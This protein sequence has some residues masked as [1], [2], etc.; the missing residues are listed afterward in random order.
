MSQQLKRSNIRSA[1]LLAC[2]S[3]GFARSPVHLPVP[4]AVDEKVHEFD[5]LNLDARRFHVHQRLFA[6]E[7]KDKGSAQSFTEALQLV[8]FFM[9]VFFW[10][11]HI[12]LSFS[13]K[14]KPSHLTNTTRGILT[15]LILMNADKF[16][17]TSFSSVFFSWERLVRMSCTVQ[18]NIS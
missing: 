8:L 15:S 6:P 4:G 18:K 3:L 10:G 5:H 12:H 14:S 11:R 1:S 7:L 2:D 17:A 16:R 13:H 9:F